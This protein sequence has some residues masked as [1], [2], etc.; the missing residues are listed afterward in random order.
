MIADDHIMADVLHGSGLFWLCLSVF[1]LLY[2]YIEL[3]CNLYF[4]CHLKNLNVSD[5]NHIVI[6]QSPLKSLLNSF[7]D[8]TVLL[9]M[10]QIEQLRSHLCNIV[11]FEARMHV[12]CL[13][14]PI[15]D[16]AITGCRG[17]GKG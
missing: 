4:L 16:I 8:L 2:I 5:M 1:C 13:T 7:S 11:C 15:Q 17:T 12:Q 6:S 14:D 3:S 10:L 9:T